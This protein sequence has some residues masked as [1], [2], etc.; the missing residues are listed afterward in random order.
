MDLDPYVAKSDSASV[1]ISKGAGVG[2]WVP[3]KDC[4]CMSDGDLTVWGDR[5]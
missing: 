1:V 5:L 2:W 3:K 4:H